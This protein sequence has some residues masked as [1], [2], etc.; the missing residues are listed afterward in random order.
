MTRP[1][2]QH[3]KVPGEESLLFLTYRLIREGRF[4]KNLTYPVSIV[5]KQSM[6]D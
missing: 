3:R 2:I 6:G 4:K 1:Y 5:K